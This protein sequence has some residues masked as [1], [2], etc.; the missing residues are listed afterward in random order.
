[1]RAYALDVGSDDTIHNYSFFEILELILHSCNDI[2]PRTTAGYI[3]QNII[4]LY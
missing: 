2:F 1:M 4:E 3:V